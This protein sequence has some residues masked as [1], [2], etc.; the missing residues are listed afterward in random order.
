MP[1]GTL[2][3]MQNAAE[4]ANSDQRYHKMHQKGTK[5][6]IQHAVIISCF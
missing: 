5:S 2:N 6:A 1:R 4:N 3:L